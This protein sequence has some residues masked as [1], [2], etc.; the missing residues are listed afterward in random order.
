MVNSLDEKVKEFG[1]F[2]WGRTRPSEPSEEKAWLEKIEARFEECKI[3]G[4][5]E[6]CIWGGELSSENF[7]HGRSEGVPVQMY[8]EY[9]DHLYKRETTLEERR[10]Y[11]E[12]LRHF[13]KMMKIP[14]GY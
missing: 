12:E 11:S 9:C 8:C 10:K 1:G 2:L 14:A 6:P 13:R 7:R 3:S 4:H 5:K